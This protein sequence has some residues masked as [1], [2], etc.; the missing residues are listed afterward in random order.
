MSIQRTT[1]HP[2]FEENQGWAARDFVGVIG[3]VGPGATAVFMD[4]LVRATRAASDQE[5]IN[6]LVAQHPEI[7]D[8]TAFILDPGSHDD[9]GPYLA[10]DAR[11]LESAGAS[12]LVLPCNTAHHFVAHVHDAVSI[13]L[14]SIVGATVRAA[15]ERLASRPAHADTRPTVAILATEGNIQ[16]RVYQD[17]LEASGISAM[18]PSAGEQ[19]CINTLIYEQVKAG[20]RAD[21][22]ALMGLVD[23]LCARG[24]D[25]VVF[26]CT[27]LSLIFDKEHMASDPRIVD[28]LRELAIATVTR[29]GRELSDEFAH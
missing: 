15:R 18:I 27:E 23:D 7:P 28:S 25:L 22:P 3:G 21:V 13:D 2:G 9:P 19:R 6:A 10:A 12:F 29:A 5:H 20:T 14:V 4:V 8:R 11:F 16:A 1:G 24:A 17:A 26:G